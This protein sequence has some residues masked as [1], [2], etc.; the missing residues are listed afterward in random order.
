ME[1]LP[2]H[3]SVSVAGEPTGNLATRADNLP[4]ISV[5]PPTEFDGPGDQWSPEHLLMA[6]LASCL[7]LSFRA[8]AAASRLQWDAISCDCTGELEQVERK[9][10]FTR[11]ISRVA[12]TLPVDGDRDKALKLLHKAEENCFISN[13]LNAEVVLE[14]DIQLAG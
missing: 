11:V 5:A 3:Y 1:K 2:H 10:G 12:L 7:V 4:P 6:S 8:I 9:I 13:S 14:C